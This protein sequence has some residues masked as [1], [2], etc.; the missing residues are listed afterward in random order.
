MVPLLRKSFNLEF[1]EE[2]YQKYLQALNAPHPGTLD[3]RVAET[4]V[5]CDKA[6]TEKMLS[7]CESIVDVIAAPTFKGNPKKLFLQQLMCPA[8]MNIPS[9]LHSI[10][11]FVKMKKGNWNHS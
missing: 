3:F 11:V 9:L 1:S 7:A 10:L 8:R 6:F 5:F 4:P 2:I